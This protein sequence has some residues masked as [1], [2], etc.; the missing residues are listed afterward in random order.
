MLP[1]VVLAIPAYR[2]L[3][4]RDADVD[5]E[6]PE[7]LLSSTDPVRGG[8]NHVVVNTWQDHVLVSVGLDVSDTPPH[9]AHREWEGETTTTLFMPGG[10]L[11]LD[12]P[13]LPSLGPWTV[14]TPGRYTVHVAWRG[15]DEVFEGLQ[16]LMDSTVDEK[17]WQRGVHALA[18][19]ERYRVT[20]VRQGRIR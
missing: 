17:A 9:H 1:A 15:R 14:G 13:T 12:Q 4:L 2:F 11:Y 5:T 16:A 3:I 10:D 7:T 18:G 6:V 20:L 19:V 8:D